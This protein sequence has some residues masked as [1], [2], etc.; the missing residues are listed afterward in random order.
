MRTTASWQRVEAI[1]GKCQLKGEVALS[2]SSCKYIFVFQQWKLSTSE[3]SFF[4]Q[5]YLNLLKEQIRG[6]QVGTEQRVARG[7][8]STP[9][10]QKTE[11]HLHF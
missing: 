6:V 1:V 4:E 7:V 5:K 3:G 11:R 10:V 2:A 8:P 9:K